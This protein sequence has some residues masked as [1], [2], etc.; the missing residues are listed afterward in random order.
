MPVG[1]PVRIDRALLGRRFDGGYAVLAGQ[2]H[3]GEV[4]ADDFVPHRLWQRVDLA[5]AFAGEDAGVRHQDIEPAIC[6]DDLAKRGFHLSF[7]AHVDVDRESFPAVP[8]DALDGRGAGGFVPIEDGDL[9][10][11]FGK[12]LRGRATNS[13]AGARYRSDFS[14]ESPH[15]L[16]FREDATGSEFRSDQTT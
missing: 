7:V 13:G 2:I 14:L 8:P 16:S 5:V 1:D 6:F 11:F 9:A 3:S 12:P 10:A 4:H 15:A